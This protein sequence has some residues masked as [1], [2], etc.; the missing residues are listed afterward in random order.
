MV[1]L[2]KHS[3]KVIRVHRTRIGWIAY[4]HRRGDFLRIDR[5]KN[6]KLPPGDHPPAVGRVDMTPRMAKLW[7]AKR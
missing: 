4:H 2:R 7:A 1:V 3:T 6:I 5:V